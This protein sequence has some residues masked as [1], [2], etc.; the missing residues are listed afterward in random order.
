MWNNINTSGRLPEALRLLDVSQA[1]AKHGV[2]YSIDL[3]CNTNAAHMNSIA[4]RSLL[5]PQRP[6]DLE[7]K[8]GYRN[9]QITGND[10]KH[11]HGS[12]K[13]NDMKVHITN[14]VE[15]GITPVSKLS[16]K[17]SMEDLDLPSQ[18]PGPAICAFQ[19]TPG[20][21]PNLNESML[22]NSSQSPL[23]TPNSAADIAS[24]PKTSIQHP[25]QGQDFDKK[26]IAR[27]TQGMPLAS[28]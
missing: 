12:S 16:R 11:G 27:H 18:R 6:W 7:K 22:F 19:I 9:E 8:K 15:A 24:T 1:V 3:E 4:A 10:I 17:S 21:P 13:D 28:P 26:R 14:T 20:S 23:S 25:L 5:G 2:V